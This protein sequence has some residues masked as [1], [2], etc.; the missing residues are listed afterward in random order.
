M[1]NTHAA[2]IRES[3]AP[4]ILNDVVIDTELIARKSKEFIQAHCTV[5]KD[6]LQDNVK[7][8]VI[9][10]LNFLFNQKDVPTRMASLLSQRKR[11]TLRH[12]LDSMDSP[13]GIILNDWP[14]CI[15]NCPYYAN[16]EYPIGIV[17]I[18][19]DKYPQMRGVRSREDKD[20]ALKMQ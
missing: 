7:L 12:L 20:D 10:F 18:K 6:A 2:V 14:Y 17:G 16:D 9:A 15:E 3:Q 1:G 8:L 19:L 4:S 13:Y 11:E 5:D